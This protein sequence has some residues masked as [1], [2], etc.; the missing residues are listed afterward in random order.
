VIFMVDAP[1][2]FDF[3]SRRKDERILELFRF[4]APRKLQC[5]ECGAIF[6]RAVFEKNLKQFLETQSSHSEHLID[7]LN[8]YKD[9]LNWECPSCNESVHLEKSET[10][11]REKISNS[12]EKIQ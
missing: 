9:L 5:P 8:S 12:G 4:E 6:H 3:R 11:Y 7:Q 10:N 2:N 1:D